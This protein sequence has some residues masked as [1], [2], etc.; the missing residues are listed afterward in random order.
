VNVAL[1]LAAP[2][3]GLA[4]AVAFPFIGIVLLVARA[5]HGAEKNAAAAA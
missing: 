1:F 5:T 2:F 4:Y 3:I